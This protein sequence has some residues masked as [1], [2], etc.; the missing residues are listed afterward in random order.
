MHPRAGKAEV[1]DGYADVNAP[2]MYEHDSAVYADY[3]ESGQFD[4]D[5]AR[6]RKLAG[7]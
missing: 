1:D 6:L 4:G 7:K 2:A 5:A 3:C